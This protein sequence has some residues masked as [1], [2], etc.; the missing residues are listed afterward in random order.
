[1]LHRQLRQCRVD[2]LVG[3][4]LGQDLPALADAQEEWVWRDSF[5][6]F[7]DAITARYCVLPPASPEVGENQTART[8]V[9]LTAAGSNLQVAV[10]QSVVQIAN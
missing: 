2:A 5:C 7:L 3:E 9:I 1:M 4:D 6:T 8:G 10:A